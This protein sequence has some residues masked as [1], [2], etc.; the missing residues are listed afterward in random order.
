MDFLSHI[1]QILQDNRQNLCDRSYEI[2]QNLRESYKIEQHSKENPME[3]LIFLDKV[4]YH[5]RQEVK[6]LVKKYTSVYLS[7]LMQ[8]RRF[9]KG[10]ME[11]LS[12]LEK[13]LQESRHDHMNPIRSYRILNKIKW[14]PQQ[15]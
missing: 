8:K 4:L 14:N 7:R 10:P 2:L 3:S 12:N 11:S 9:K 15:F 6:N 13:I 1:E 5:L